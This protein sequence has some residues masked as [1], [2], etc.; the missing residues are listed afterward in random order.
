MIF[1]MLRI[2]CFLKAMWYVGKMSVTATIVSI[3]LFKQFVLL[4]TVFNLQAWPTG[5]PQGKRKAECC[6]ESGYIKNQPTELLLARD[7]K[8][9]IAYQ[10]E[11]ELGD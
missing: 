9:S 7:I 2:Y 6:F 8:V 1:W 5:C 3:S 11:I 10:L 4:E